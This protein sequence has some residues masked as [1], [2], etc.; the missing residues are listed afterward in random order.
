VVKTKKIC[1]LK[2]YFHDRASKRRDEVEQYPNRNVTA[3]TIPS[4]EAP[5]ESKVSCHIT[6]EFGFSWLR[7]KTEPGTCAA[8]HKYNVGK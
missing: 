4:T 2:A 5:N 6:E 7:G 1:T 8:V 3:G